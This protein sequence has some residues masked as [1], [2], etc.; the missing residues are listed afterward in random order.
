MGEMKRIFAVSD[1]HGYF[2]QLKKALDEAGFDPENENHLLVCCGDYFDRGTEN[3]QVLKFFER[4]K[5]KVL[6]KGNHEDMLE[7]IFQTGDFKPHNYLNGTVQ[8]INE[9]F[10]KYALDTENNKVDFSGQTGNLNR[11]C[12]FFDEL[13]DYFETKNYIFTHGWLP[14]AENESGFAVLDDWRNA[15]PNEWEK[16]RWK[17][18]NEMYE[19]CDRVA[20]KTIVCGHVPTFYASKFDKSRT[21]EDSS[22]F[23]GEGVTVIDAGTF[24]S[25]R[26]NVL[27]IEDE[28]IQ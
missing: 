4:L 24:T 18:W 26:T 23:Y 16:A 19:I 25:G 8:T 15:S 11:V 13:Q 1:V 21:P 17:K 6:L 20:D 7:K 2:S 22:V 10:G 27:V 14:T 5:H 12:E 28:L 3:M 9:F